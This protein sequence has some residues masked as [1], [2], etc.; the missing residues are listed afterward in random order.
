MS[1]LVA[2]LERAHT[3]IHQIAS[4]ETRIN[5]D[6]QQLYERGCARQNDKDFKKIAIIA[7]ITAPVFLLLMWIL[8]ITGVLLA[9]QLGYIAGAAVIV[10]IAAFVVSKRYFGNRNYRV[11][12]MFK[13]Y[14][15]ILITF[16]LAILFGMA[17]ISM[18][19]RINKAELL[20]MPL[21]ALIMALL[22]TSIPFLI[23]KFFSETKKLARKEKRTQSTASDEEIIARIDANSQQL[24]R[25]HGDMQREIRPWYPEGFENTAAVDWFLQG[26]RQQ[27]FDTVKEMVNEYETYL[28]RQRLERKQNDIYNQQ[29]QISHDVSNIAADTRQNTQDLKE[30]KKV[31]FDED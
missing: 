19:G 29:L 1:D 17:S 24:Y 25:L 16:L 2:R 21:T 7:M 15:Y 12:Q 10:P 3:L 4:L 18:P 5:Q 22:L 26:A 11:Q 31:F 8:R 9:S 28:H 14:R 20:L 27:R 6:R 23:L 13:K 30:I